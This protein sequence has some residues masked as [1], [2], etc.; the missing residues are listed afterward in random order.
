MQYSRS[1]SIGG[2]SSLSPA[3]PALASRTKDPPSYHA[4]GQNN[5]SPKLSYGNVYRPPTCHIIGFNVL[6]DTV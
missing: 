2:V 3:R 5:A 4:V 1:R 6:L